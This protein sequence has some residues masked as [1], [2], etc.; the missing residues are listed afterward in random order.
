MRI[1]ERAL[2]FSRKA[3]PLLKALLTI[4]I[5]SALL[6]VGFLL[7]THR[8]HLYPWS[9]LYKYQ[10]EIQMALAATAGVCFATLIYFGATRGRFVATTIIAFILMGATAI[11]A[12]LVGVAEAKLGL[13]TLLGL[14]ALPSTAAVATKA[15]NIASQKASDTRIHKKALESVDAA[16]REEH[17]AELFL[18]TV[19]W[20]SGG[21]GVFLLS[22][23]I[24]MW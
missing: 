17:L 8:I 3:W 10:T 11:T 16:L 18:W 15:A 21:L 2:N 7:W 20:A 23:A 9:P 6:A 19:A 13:G 12:V 5:A 22:K 4:A 24:E 14:I 1:L